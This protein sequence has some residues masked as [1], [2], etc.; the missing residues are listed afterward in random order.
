[1]LEVED[2]CAVVYRVLDLD[3]VDIEA[4]RQVAESGLAK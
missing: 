3:D 2:D 1:V 4:P